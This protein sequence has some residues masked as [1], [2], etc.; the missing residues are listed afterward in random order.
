MGATQIRKWGNSAAVR[1]SNAALEG[2]HF[3]IDQDVA[4]AV[5]PGR[6]VIE[7]AIPNYNLETMLA[8]VTD[9]NLPHFEGLSQPVGAEVIEW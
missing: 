2:A 9:T 6:I 3:S 4:I 7:A 8:S 5:S 1:L